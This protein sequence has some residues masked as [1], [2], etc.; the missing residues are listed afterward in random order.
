MDA[1][2]AGAGRRHVTL[3][4]DLL[5]VVSLLAQEGEPTQLLA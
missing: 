4:R 3:K 1:G 2:G 5:I